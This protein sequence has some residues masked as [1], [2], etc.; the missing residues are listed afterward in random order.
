MAKNNQKIYLLLASLFMIVNACS[1]ERE[2]AKQYL[3]TGIQEDVMVMIPDHV[4]KTSLKQ[5]EIDSAEEMDEWTLDS[6]LYAKSLFIQYISDSL[7]L[8][9]YTGSYITELKKLGIRVY[10]EEWMDTFLLLQKPA[11]VINLTQIE[12]EEYVMPFRDEELIEEY[13]FYKEIDLNMVCINSWFEL[14]R[15]N[16]EDEEK[17][18]LFASHYV[19]DEFDGY[20]KFYP[21]TGEVS[22]S[23]SIDTLV[24][25]EIYGLAAFLGRKYAGYTFDYF[26]N[27][28]I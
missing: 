1:V 4:Y 10:I 24:V 15:M 28:H 25:N 17:Q 3:E 27:M 12:I 9:Q 21:F 2:L 26:L 19:S 16:T 7:F 11:L 8:E 18:V 22:Y 5:Y 23:Y 6:T 14:T 20:F 13:L